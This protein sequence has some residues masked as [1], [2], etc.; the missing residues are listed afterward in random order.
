MPLLSA[1]RNMVG[2]DRGYASVQNEDDKANKDIKGCFLLR[3]T[4]LAEVGVQGH[5]SHYDLNKYWG[6]KLALNSS[7]VTLLSQTSFLDG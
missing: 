2:E 4:G 7:V 1:F 5:A 6:D 3:R